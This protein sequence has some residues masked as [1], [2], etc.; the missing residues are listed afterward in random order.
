MGVIRILLMSY[1]ALI[2]AVAHAADCIR[3]WPATFLRG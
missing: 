3:T 1:R 2:S